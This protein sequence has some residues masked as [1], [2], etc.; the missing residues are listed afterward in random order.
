[1][2]FFGKISVYEFRKKYRTYFSLALTQR[3]LKLFENDVSMLA[4]GE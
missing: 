4:Y 3:I 1:M 2:G